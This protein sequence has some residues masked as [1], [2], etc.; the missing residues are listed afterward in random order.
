MPDA[1]SFGADPAL[2]DRL[3]TLV[4]KGTKTATSS[5]LWE[6]EHDRSPLPR[7]G[8]LGI[9]LDGRGAP[10]CLI[11]TTDVRV[12]PFD[13]VPAEFAHAEG[14]G[15][16]TLAT[17]REAHWEFFSRFLPRIGLEAT[18]GMPLVCERFRVVCL[19]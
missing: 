8:D 5:A 16:R 19:A 4:V 17:W 3:G 15:D 1:W 10:L 13:E 6:Y 7:V 18:R 2:A 9:V 11:E 14:E 12:R